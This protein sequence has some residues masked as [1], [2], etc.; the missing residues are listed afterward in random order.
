MGGC[1]DPAS[2][3]LAESKM[4]LRPDGGST[5]GRRT[6]GRMQMLDTKREKRNRIKCVAIVARLKP[7][8]AERAGELLAAGPPFDLS[9]TGIER[10]SVFLSAGEVAFIFEGHEIDWI[11]D[12]LIDGPSRYE[13]VHAFDDWRGIVDGPPRIAR[14]QFAWDSEGAAI[15]GRATGA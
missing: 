4:G 9:D 13:L 8:T 11:I 15:A 12:D 7:G 1:P 3:E 5:R 2:A 14:E 6:F 10:H